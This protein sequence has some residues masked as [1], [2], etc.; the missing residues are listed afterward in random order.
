MYVYRTCMIRGSKLI[1]ECGVYSTL[2][3]ELCRVANAL[4][5]P[6]SVETVCVFTA[7]VFSA[8]AA[9]STYALTKVRVLLRLPVRKPLIQIF[10]RIFPK[11]IHLSAP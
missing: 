8:F 1:S 3:T 2:M 11:I 5:I 9:W 7:P 4:N 6:L 10:L